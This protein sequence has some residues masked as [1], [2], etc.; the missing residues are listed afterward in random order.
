MTVKQ[1]LKRLKELSKFDIDDCEII[2]I[3]KDGEL[4]EV[5]NIIYDDGKIEFEMNRI[6]LWLVRGMVKM[7]NSILYGVLFGLI[8]SLFVTNYHL[9]QKID[10]LEWGIEEL[11]NIQDRNGIY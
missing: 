1:L 3:D 8:I 7:L 2:L 10:E 6:K 9:Q 4:Q 5:T 11:K